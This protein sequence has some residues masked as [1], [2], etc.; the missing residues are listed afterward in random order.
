MDKIGVREVIEIGGY[1][2]NEHT[3]IMTWITMAFVIIVAAL[4]S[5]N[6]K[7]VPTGFFQSMVEMIVDLIVAKEVA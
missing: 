2:F 5:R 7:E 4:A 3:I 6:V 1:M